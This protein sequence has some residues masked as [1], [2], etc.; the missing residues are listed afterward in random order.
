MEFKRARAIEKVKR[1]KKFHGHLRAYLVVNIGLLFLR[2]SGLGFVVNGIE[3][4]SEGFLSWIDWNIV[5]IPLLW[6]V[7]LF[8]HAARTF[9]WIPIFG[10]KWEERKIKEFMDKDKKGNL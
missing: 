10:E 6:G 9:D 4:T 5:A 7:G 3:N 2:F 8:I 1:I